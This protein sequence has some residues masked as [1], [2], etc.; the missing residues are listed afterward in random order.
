M[1][2]FVV[3]PSSN[4]TKCGRF[5]DVGFSFSK[6]DTT[7][8]HSIYTEVEGYDVMFHVSTMLEHSNDEQQINKKRFIG[9]D[10]VIILFKEGNTK[11]VPKF[12]SHFNRKWRSRYFLSVNLI[13]F[14]KMFLLLFK[15]M[16]NILA[17]IWLVLLERLT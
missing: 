6:G 16:K 5:V 3:L 9:N 14:K 8:T 12:R 2:Q 4:F 17:I 10:I 11:I 1:Y 13:Y 15:K 7:G